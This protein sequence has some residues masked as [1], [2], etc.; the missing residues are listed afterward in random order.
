M[1]WITVLITCSLVVHCTSA[2]ECYLCAAHEV[3]L[4]GQTT[5]AVSKVEENIET[6]LTYLSLDVNDVCLSNQATE[7]NTLQDTDSCENDEKCGLLDLTMVTSKYK[8]FE[9]D[10]LQI[11]LVIR[12]CIETDQL[13]GC[14]T[15]AEPNSVVDSYIRL[16]YQQFQGVPSSSEGCY[17]SGYNKC[18]VNIYTM[19]MSPSTPG[20]STPTSQSEG[21][22]STSDSGVVSGATS[23]LARTFMD[24]FIF[25]LVLSLC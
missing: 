8:D 15:E 20:N 6:V 19:M 3:R 4:N 12:G 16:L 1:F 13:D 7:L 25:V 5:S 23:V 24:I 10:I 9:D 21:D 22:G 11:R 2:L 14:Y 17:C 18:N